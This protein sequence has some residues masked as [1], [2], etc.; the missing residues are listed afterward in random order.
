MD[1]R[2]DGNRSVGSRTSFG[3]EWYESTEGEREAHSSNTALSQECHFTMA[4]DSWT[5]RW[6]QGASGW[7]K[8]NFL[9]QLRWSVCNP[10]S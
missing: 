6:P 4:R 10:V 9:G 1:G 8:D 7:R 5:P 3:R 2:V